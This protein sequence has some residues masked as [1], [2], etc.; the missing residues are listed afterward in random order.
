MNWPLQSLASVTQIISGGTPKSGVEE[1][2]EG[3]VQWLTPADMGK[4]T[5]IYV[6]DTRRKITQL[7]LAKSSAKL[8]PTNSVILSTRAPIG[9][10]AINTTP[11]A[12]NQGCRGLIPNE[13]VDTKYLYYFLYSNVEL[14]NELG[15]GTTF[16]ELSKSELEKVR[17]PTPKIEE[18]KRIVAILDQAFA[19]ID[20][21]RAVAERNLK[22]ARELFDSYLQQ[23]FSQR[24]DSS[25]MIKIS[26]LSRVC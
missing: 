8:F 12:T 1:F 18:Q 9:H 16:K 13:S 3:D 21:A 19:D 25:P 20:K 17:L 4:M 10:L 6:S 15:T 14:L 23:V 5:G 11:M 7:G 2:W 26:E 22:N 24:D